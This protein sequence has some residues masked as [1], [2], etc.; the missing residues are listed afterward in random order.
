MLSFEVPFRMESTSPRLSQKNCTVFRFNNLPRT[1]QLIT[2]G[3][4]SLAIMV[5]SVP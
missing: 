1:E 4:S 2:M 3:T 5:V